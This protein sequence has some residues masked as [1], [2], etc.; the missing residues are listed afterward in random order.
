MYI[1]NVKAQIYLNK[2]INKKTWLKTD[3]VNAYRSSLVIVS[4]RS[5]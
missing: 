2:K 3:F 5:E 4:V 1:Y